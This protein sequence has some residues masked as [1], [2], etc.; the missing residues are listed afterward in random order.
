MSDQ[1]ILLIR[2]SIALARFQESQSHDLHH[3]LGALVPKLHRAIALPNDKPTAAL[4]HFVIRYIEHVPDF[5]E[6]LSHLMKEAR[7]E[8]YGQVFLSIAEDYFLKPLELTQQ[9][10]GL[11]ALIDEAYLAHRLIEEI[12]DRL[13]MLCGVPLT[14]MDMTLSNIIIHDILGEAFANQLDLAVYYAIEALFLPENLANNADLS[15][16]VQQHNATDW[17]NALARW[18]CLAGDSAIALKFD[19]GVSTKA[20]IH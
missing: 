1:N 14:P 13:L 10:S 19:N 18:P 20:D 11:L 6:A 12:N 5:L 4:Q 16:F 7:I 3:Y 15:H 9:H 17:S 8:Q 2:E